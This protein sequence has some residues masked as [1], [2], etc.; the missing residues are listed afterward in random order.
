METS[1]FQSTN[2]GLTGL[3]DFLLEGTTP[4]TR[5]LLV[6]TLLALAVLPLAALSGTTGKIAGEVNN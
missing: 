2:E 1:L 5:K 6:A 4:M 3:I